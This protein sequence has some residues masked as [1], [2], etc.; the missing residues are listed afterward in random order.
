[1]SNMASI[2]S[3]HHLNVINPLKTQAYGCNCRAK[4]FCPLQNQSLTPKII[5]QGGVE[6]ETNSET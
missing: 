4:K 3:W 2:L 6:N 5:Y 1:M